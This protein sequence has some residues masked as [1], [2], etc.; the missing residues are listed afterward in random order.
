MP[1]QNQCV[2]REGWRG[3]CQER[4]LSGEGIVALYAAPNTFLPNKICLNQC[5]GMTH[6]I[7]FSETV[8]VVPVST[9]PI[10]N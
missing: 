9:A 1:G 7:A 2:D 5:V 4:A 10:S 6:F 3:H 8:L